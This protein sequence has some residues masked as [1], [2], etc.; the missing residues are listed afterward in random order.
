MTDELKCWSVAYTARGKQ[1]SMHVVATQ[2][3]IDTHV[4]NLGCLG[5]EV[6]V[7]VTPYKGILL[8]DGDVYVATGK[9][10]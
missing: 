7:A 2:E 8:Q 5:A 1:F 9:L 10:N 4:D 6:L 3:E